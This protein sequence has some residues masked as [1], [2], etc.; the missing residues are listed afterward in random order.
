M[1]PTERLQL[2]WGEAA[3][4]SQQASL[5][6]LDLGHVRQ[7]GVLDDGGPGARRGRGGALA[8]GARGRELD[9]SLTPLRWKGEGSI[10]NALYIIFVS[11]HDSLLLLSL[12]F[13]IHI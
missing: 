13:F 10:V 12:F 1:N 9:L 4:Q 7:G 6:L 11:L 5:H 3:E 8:P 2:S